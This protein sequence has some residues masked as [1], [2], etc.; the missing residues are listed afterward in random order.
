MK[1]KLKTSFQPA[2]DQPQAIEKLTKSIG[3]DNKHQT[4]LGVTGSGK[5][6]TVAK[7]IEKLQLPTLIISHNKTLASQLYQEFRDFFPKNAVSYFVSY[8]D[9]YQPE[10]YIPQS[11]TYIEKETSINPEIDKLRLTTTSNLLTRPDT[12]VVASV[13]CIYG[14]G[15]PDSQEGQLLYLTPGQ[16]INRRTLVSHL[17]SLQYQ[18]TTTTLTRGTFRLIGNHL[19]IYPS[20]IDVVYSIKLD[21]LRINTIEALDPLNFTPVSQDK[22]ITIYPAKHYLANQTDQKKVFKQ[23][24]HDLKQQIKY[25]KENKMPLEAHRIEQKVEYDLQMI[26]EMGYV[27]GIENYSRYFDGREKGSPPYTLLDY[28]HYNVKKFKAKDFLTVVDESHISLPQIKGMYRG[29]QS[30]KTNLINFG[31][32]LPASLDNRPLTYTEFQNRSHLNLYTS[33]TPADY[34]LS[35]SKTGKI[36][37]IAKQVIRP[38]GLLDPEIFVLPTKNQINKITQE[39]LE[40]KV[41][42]ERVLVLTITKKMAEELAEHLSKQKN[43]IR[44]EYLHSDIKTLD[45]G[46]ILDNLRKGEFDCLIG[47]NLLREGLDLPEVSLIAILDADKEGFLRTPSSLIQIM[48]RAARH[49]NGQVMLFADRVSQSMKEAMDTTNDRRKIQK[50]FNSKN[51][52]TPKSIS[53]PIRDRLLK[54]ELEIEKPNQ[55][56][57]LGIDPNSLTPKDKK[58]LATKLKTL[59]NQ[60]AKTWDFEKAAK[61][62][63]LLKT[64]P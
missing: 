45:R 14:L 54:K 22:I 46:D 40:R 37:T 38:T 33:A 20:Q 15:S 31:F 58:K 41:K 34:E 52:I 11:D 23:I 35:L 27:N 53:K 8:Y 2:G 19:E 55:D 26:Q 13:S 30:R 51:N 12:I 1:F 42:G 25:F 62:R 29:D 21:E 7:I 18:R 63:D 49:A 39:I 9:Y 16:V 59:M 57:E 64:F 5:T 44:A 24:R 61:I 43:S 56:P 6:F 3:Q 36:P 47:I 50:E 28:F 60:A 4:L 10:A 48:G 32:R 17:V